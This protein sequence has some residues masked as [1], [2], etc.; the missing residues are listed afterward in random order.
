MSRPF[1]D[2]ERAIMQKFVDRIYEEFLGKVASGRNM[3]RDQVDTI[4]QGRV[5]I[6]KDALELGLV[7][8]LG[9]MDTA[10]TIAARMAG[11]DNYV[12]VSYP[13]DN[14]PMNEFFRDFNLNASLEAYLQEKYG[15]YMEMMERYESIQTMK[16]VQAR[17]PFYM[18]IK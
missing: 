8:M 11:I 6:G 10:V 16:T 4:A 17:M 7:D 5:W 9:G 12:Q 13:E 3:T 2:S 1:A 18:T 14:N 15:T